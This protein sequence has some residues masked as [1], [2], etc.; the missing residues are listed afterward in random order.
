M[1]TTSFSE[2]RSPR[3]EG[4]V[5]VD[6]RLG[7]VRVVDPQQSLEFRRHLGGGISAVH[8]REQVEHPLTM[9]VAQGQQRTRVVGFGKV[10]QPQGISR[11]LVNGE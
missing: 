6:E 7:L 8:Q 4:G 2:K 10:C 1:R 5:G 3:A 11:R 9:R